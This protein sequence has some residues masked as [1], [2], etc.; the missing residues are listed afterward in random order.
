MASFLSN[1]G[2][3]TR[4]RGHSAVPLPCSRTQTTETQHEPELRPTRLRSPR[5]SPQGAARWFPS[6]V[7]A[8]I[9][10]Y[11]SAAEGRAAPGEPAFPETA[12]GLRHFPPR[13]PASVSAPGCN[14]NPGH[15]DA[16]QGAGLCAWGRLFL[17][18]GALIQHRAAGAPTEGGRVAQPGQL[19]S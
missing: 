12:C 15:A 5:T 8:L 7:G 4:T 13:A 9:C 11:S 3:K 10:R 14:M 2:T 16:G 18:S 17:P 19:R 6:A 1:A